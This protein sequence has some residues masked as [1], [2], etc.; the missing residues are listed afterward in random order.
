[1]M[2]RKHSTVLPSVLRVFA[3]A[4]VAS[5]L[6]L[7]TAFAQS[8]PRV[9]VTSESASV[10]SMR[11]AKSEK[12]TTVA[13][14]TVLTVVYTSGD[15]YAHQDT[16]WYFV[17]LPA[18]AFGR[19]HTGWISGRSVEDF[20]PPAPPAPAAVQAPAP[21]PV[22]QPPAQPVR[23]PQKPQTV[24]KTPPAVVDCPDEPAHPAADRPAPS[25]VVVHFAFDKSELTSQAKQILDDGVKKMET[26]GASGMSFALEGYADATGPEAYNNRLGLAR[27][28]SVRRYLAEHH[29][30]PA[31]KI[32]VTSYGEDKPVASNGTREGRAANRRVV[33]KIAS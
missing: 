29:H 11:D 15:P 7:G 22:V 18:D 14:G 1:M 13:E 19:G 3:L 16:N 28:E 21:A 2:S 20:H 10:T 24:A 9:Q 8:R 17:Q 5:L 4:L 31:N 32:S 25:E 6:P 23:E 12:I 27:A 30:I 26:S 33:V